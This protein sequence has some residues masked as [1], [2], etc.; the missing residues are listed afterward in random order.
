LVRS[1]AEPTPTGM[2]ISI[3]DVWDAFICHASEDKEDVAR[4]LALALVG[5]GLDIW[6]D[7]L[8]LT[9]GDRLT[10]AIDHGLANSRYGIVV[11]SPNFFAKHWPRRELEGLV[12]QEIRH[13]Q[14]VILP[15]WHQVDAKGV[16]AHSPPLANTVAARMEDGLSRVV[17][18]LIAAMPEINPTTAV[19]STDSVHEHPTS[20]RLDADSE[21]IAGV[22]IHRVSERELDL[23]KTPDLKEQL[24]ALADAQPHVGA[25]VLDWS[26]V[27]FV[28]ATA[29]GA[30]IGL[31]RRMRADNRSVALVA[32]K[33]GVLQ[34]L[35]V[36][37]FDR[38]VPVYPTIEQ[39]IADYG[40]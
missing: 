7:E 38:I 20:A 22:A 34:V 35:E 14:K 18:D 36:T 15:V 32:D 28:D 3:G 26:G 8:S 16:A 33:R 23:W 6:Y 1:T 27:E 29:L 24:L 4:P 9:V 25:L 10:E 37:G 40:E 12:A 17:G 5:L 11:L 31:V 19:G 30:L 21:R 2:L 13:G 39:A